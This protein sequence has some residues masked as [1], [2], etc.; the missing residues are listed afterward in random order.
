[1]KRAF[2][3]TV[4]MITSLCQFT[5]MGLF[6]ASGE[7]PGVKE[8]REP[9]V[10]GMFYPGSPVLLRSTIE[11]LLQ[12][13]PSETP[14][15]QILAAIAPHAGYAYSG[16]VAAATH[17]LMVGVDFE[18]I[19]IIGH[20]TYREGVAFTCPVKYFQTPLG[21]VPVDLEM[22]ERM[23][24]FHQGIK[25]NPSVHAKDHTV[26]VHLPFLQVRD[27]PFKIVPLLFGNPTEENCRILSNAVIKAAG[28]KNV[29]ILASADMSHYPPYDEARKLD[30]KTLDVLKS[31]N[32]TKLFRHLKG[33]ERRSTAPNLQTA[34][35]ARGGVGTAILFAR[36]G[37]ANQVRV[38]Q[39]ANSGD[40]PTGGKG[41][42]VGYSSVIML[43]N[44]M[45]E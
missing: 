39:Y 14:R 25:P 1:M 13:S 20:D 45:L 40:V 4:F 41:R 29:F 15:G 21:R 36:A 7:G 5:G 24:D 31:L 34:M 8:V 23:Q 22:M 10:A 27:R 16:A 42:V 26:E 3:I 30:L 12:K 17:K 11:N 18:T 32:L 19:I 33:H 37:G 28:G 2:F 6:L 38:I 43:R 35:C 44:K 9:A